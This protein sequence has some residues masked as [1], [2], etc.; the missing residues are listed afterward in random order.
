MIASQCNLWEYRKINDSAIHLY[1]DIHIANIF[2]LFCKT[3]A[4]ASLDVRLSKSEKIVR[5]EFF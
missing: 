3:S 5:D 4:I 2:S 1:D